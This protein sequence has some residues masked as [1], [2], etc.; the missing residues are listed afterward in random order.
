MIKKLVFK[1]QL[2]NI[3]KYKSLRKFIFIYAIKKGEVVLTTGKTVS[4][5]KNKNSVSILCCKN[6]TQQEE[7]ELKKFTSFV[8][9]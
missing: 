2:G 9:K 5:S 4:F 8:C 7:K 3:L 6:L 1:D